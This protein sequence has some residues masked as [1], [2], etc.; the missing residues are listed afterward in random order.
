MWVQNHPAQDKR[1][2]PGE[3]LSTKCRWID[4]PE[5]FNTI[6]KGWYRVCFDE[7]P[8]DSGRTTDPFHNAGSLHLW[9]FEQMFDPVSMREYGFAPDVRNFEK[10][11]RNTM[12][13][14]RD[15]AELEEEYHIW[16]AAK[17]AESKQ[18]LRQ[19]P[20]EPV[21]NRPPKHYLG[22]ALT[23]RHIILEG[24]T[25]GIA[26][27]ERDGADISKHKGDLKR[28]LQLKERLLR[29]KKEQTE[30]LRKE[31]REKARLNPAP[32]PTSSSDREVSS[33]EPPARRS[34]ARGTKRGRTGTEEEDEPERRRGAKRRRAT[35]EKLGAD[36]DEDWT[37]DANW[38]E[39]RTPRLLSP[40][41]DRR[42]APA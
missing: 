16:M 32:S 14:T 26:R 30:R 8:T 6:L 2:H 37:P 31:K 25:R 42:P 40:L 7:R 17:E 36:D 35:I 15:H 29:E 20:G 11:E 19:H 34:S 39:S 10:E 28:Y 38:M 22:A 9:C 33:T 4:C 13:L 18:Y 1:R 5:R 41:R 21:P 27:A 23:K 24:K 3:A 12:S